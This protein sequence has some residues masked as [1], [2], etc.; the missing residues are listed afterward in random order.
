MKTV[1]AQAPVR[2]E[3][4][5]GVLTVTAGGDVGRVIS[6][7]AGEVTTLGRVEEATVRFDDVSLSRVHARMMRVG[8]AYVLTDAG[9]TNGSY[10][11]DQRV[12]TPVTLKDGDRVQLGSS[13]TLRFSLVDAAE[14]EALRKVYEASMRDALTGVYNRKHLEEVLDTEIAF[15]LRN[16][17]HLSV[18]MIDVDFFKRVNDTF[19]HLAGDAVLRQLGSTLLRGVRV[20][21]AVARYGG[22]EF[23]IVSR[24]IDAYNACLLADRIRW[25]VSQTPVIH[26]TQ[27]IWVTASAGVAS[28]LCCGD[29][30]DKAT[31]LETAD[32]RL[33]QA[34]EGG[35]NRVVGPG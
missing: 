19:G 20:E 16:Q 6:I 5:R 11:N 18:V 14:E 26:H 13:T 15:A 33:Y 28:L 34:K 27:Q 21:D 24:G 17:A 22:E 29:K 3:R 32:K 35:R 23:M 4:S 10:V 31:L 9:S 8:M 1:V 12:T 2:S 30:H 25:T 7:P